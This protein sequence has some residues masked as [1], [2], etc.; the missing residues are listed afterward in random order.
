MREQKQQV[1]LALL[2]IFTTEH[3][4]P[5]ARSHSNELASLPLR[6]AREVSCRIRAVGWGSEDIAKC[7]ILRGDLKSPTLGH[8]HPP[9][10][11]CETE[12]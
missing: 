7:H 1:S 10:P 6:L 9:E 4:P 11:S 12:Q 2:D 3:L 8:I 5:E